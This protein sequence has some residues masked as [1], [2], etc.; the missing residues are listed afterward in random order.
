MFL[1]ELDI[2]KVKLGINADAL[3]VLHALLELVS[4]GILVGSMKAG[5]ER[6]GKR[7]SFYG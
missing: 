7:F 2:S 1:I 5:H 4:K 6:F 3:S